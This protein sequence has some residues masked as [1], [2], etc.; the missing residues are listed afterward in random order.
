V[1]VQTNQPT[2]A[3]G[4]MG[5]ITVTVKNSLT[6]TPISGAKIALDLAL[7]TGSAAHYV[8]YADSTGTLRLSLFVNTAAQSGIYKLVATAS[9]GVQTG[10]G[11]KTFSVT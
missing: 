2:Y 6:Q 11:Q 1:T 7:P 4:T 3:K 5:I 9:N 10:T 8:F